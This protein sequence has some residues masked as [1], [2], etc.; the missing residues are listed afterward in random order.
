M[1]GTDTHTER[2]LLKREGGNGVVHAQSPV[3]PQPLSAPPKAG[4]C[5]RPQLCASFE[6]KPA[7]SITPVLPA[8]NPSAS[9]S[10]RSVSK[11]L[12]GQWC[13]L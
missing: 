10:C 11:K 3:C 5:G 6:E 12:S 8:Q 9:L 13:E 1:L 4:L 2:A 7:M